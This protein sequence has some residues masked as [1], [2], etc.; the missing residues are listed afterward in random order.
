VR[1]EG[2]SDMAEKVTDA[3]LKQVF[4]GLAKPLPNF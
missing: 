2:Y 4:V 3:K 1:L